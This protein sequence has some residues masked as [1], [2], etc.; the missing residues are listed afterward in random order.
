MTGSSPGTQNFATVSIVISAVSGV[1][2]LLS[3][4]SLPISTDTEDSI[5]IAAFCL[6]GLAGLTGVTVTLYV[7]ARKRSF[8]TRIYVALVMGLAAFGLSYFT[9]IKWLETWMPYIFGVPTGG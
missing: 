6:G 4:L 8:S 2:C 7:L 9:L 5:F 1:L 3:L